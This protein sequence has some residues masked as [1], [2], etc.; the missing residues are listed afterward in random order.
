M[1]KAK[2]S[3]AQKIRWGPVDGLPAGFKIR[4]GS[5]IPWKRLAPEIEVKLLRQVLEVPPE[6]K[7]VLLDFAGK[8]D[9]L[10]RI[11]GADGSVIGG[12]W[13]GPNPEIDGALWDGFIRV[14]KSFRP[15]VI[16]GV[17]QRWSD[18]TYRRLPL[19]RMSSQR[20]EGIVEVNSSVSSARCEPDLSFKVF[21]LGSQDVPPVC[22]GA[23]LSEAEATQ[24]F[25]LLF[26]TPMRD[27]L[28]S[29]DPYFIHEHQATLPIA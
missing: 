7:V 18:G 9:W 10:V 16:W 6:S 11:L 29:L 1:P 3:R 2:T 24:Q 5:F 27:G 8:P 26:H 12:I 22:A 28:R 13:A 25:E 17:F 14:G 20:N 23:P 4:G 21:H 19:R 15:P